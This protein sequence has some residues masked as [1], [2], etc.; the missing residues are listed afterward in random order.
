MSLGLIFY[1]WWVQDSKCWKDLS[2]IAALCLSGSILC[3]FRKGGVMC[4]AWHCAF[5]GRASAAL[6]RT[7]VLRTS[8]VI[9]G[10]S[11]A[12]PVHGRFAVALRRRDRDGLVH[13]GRLS[14]TG[15]GARVGGRALHGK[16]KLVNG[17]IYNLFSCNG[18]ISSSCMTLNP[19]NKKR[20]DCILPLLQ[21]CTYTAI[22]V[23]SAQGACH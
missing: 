7:P 6:R 12:H 2:D 15:S 18:S 5:P 10:G 17:F 9:F 21:A 11:L 16:L 23:L 22:H 8:W 14:G 20:K 4:K 19:K 1:V 3:S 13:V